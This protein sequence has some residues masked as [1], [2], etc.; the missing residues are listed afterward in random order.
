[1]LKAAGL[2]LSLGM[3]PVW[4]QSV[5]SATSGVIH[6]IEGDVRLDGKPVEMKVSKF[7]DMKKGQELTTVE[8]RAEVLLTPGAFLRL[9]ENSGARMIE[10]SLANTKVEV[11][12]GSALF[13]VAELLKDNAITVVYKDREI[14]LNKAGLYRL[15][16][17]GANFRVFE[18]E[19]QIADG[20]EATKLKKGKQ[21]DLGAVVATSKFEPGLYDSFLRWSSRRSGYVAAANVSAA[22]SVYNMGM[23]WSSSGWYWNQFFGMYTFIPRS[24]VLFS[25][26][27]FGFFSP[28]GFY[29]NYYFPRFVA[30][31]IVNND[32]WAGS[33]GTWHDAGVGYTVA[34]NRGSVAVGGGESAR[35]SA[36]GSMGGGAAAGGSSAGG[37]VG[38]GGGGR[39]R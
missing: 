5:I 31:T 11:T 37:R 2:L 24:G 36:G 28:I 34:P 7:P 32:R 1:M 14:Q 39:G 12:E 4:G 27:G 29:N 18:G 15:D 22:R 6:Y 35:G 13:E 3:L 21:A 17:E 8:G 38:G 10:N 25:P 33:R 30:P 9:A 20:S 26:F 19:A 16:A 23:P